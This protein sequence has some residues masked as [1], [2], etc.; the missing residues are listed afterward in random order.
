[1]SDLPLKHTRAPVPNVCLGV[2]YTVIHGKEVQIYVCVYLNGFCL[3]TFFIPYTFVDF[4][5][6]WIYNNT[7]FSFLSLIYNDINWIKNGKKLLFHFNSYISE[8]DVYTTT[9]YSTHKKEKQIQIKF[10]IFFLFF[11]FGKHHTSIL[12][13][14]FSWQVYKRT[15]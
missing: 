12:F 13:Y 8:N 4:A 6:F 11:F 15:L 5:Y 3:L 1:M 14:G 10:E 7:S 2:Y 9:L